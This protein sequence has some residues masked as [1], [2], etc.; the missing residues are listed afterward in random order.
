M[1]FKIVLSHGPVVWAIEL[2]AYS[3]DTGKEVDRFILNSSMD[4]GAALD[5]VIRLK[6]FTGLDTVYEHLSPRDL[7]R[8]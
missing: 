1:E 3:L 5:Y 7:N 6:K 4:Y 2:M 8:V